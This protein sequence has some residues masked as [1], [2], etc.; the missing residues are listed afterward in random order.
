MLI[1]FQ[2]KIQSQSNI[3]YSQPVESGFFFLNGTYIE[4]PYNFEVNDRAIYINGLQ[5]DNQLQYPQF[6]NRVFEDPGI[7]MD[8]SKNLTVFAIDTIRTTEGGIWILRRLRYFIQNYP[9]EESYIKC[10]NFLKDLPFI[11][12]AENHKDYIGI[13]ELKDFHGNSRYIDLNP[14]EIGPLPTLEELRQGLERSKNRLI[15]RLLKGDCKFYFT[16]NGEMSISQIKAAKILP[17]VLEVLEN[18]RINIDE[19]KEKLEKYGLVQKSNIRNQ[20]LI[21]NFIYN[22]QLHLRLDELRNNIKDEF[23]EELLEI[24][25]IKSS[26]KKQ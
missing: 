4:T 1:A 24:K 9:R 10:I 14:I 17:S 5:L 6:D 16:N 8:L 11:Q 26:K 20:I 7:P 12:S 23:G 2:I 21:D 22:N 19:K 13:V 15:D 18:D 25:E 3:D